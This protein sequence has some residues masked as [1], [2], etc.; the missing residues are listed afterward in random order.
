[1]SLIESIDAALAAATSQDAR[2]FRLELQ[3]D[4]IETLRAAGA[5]KEAPERWATAVG[6]YKTVPVY[7][8]TRDSELM[9]QPSA[10]STGLHIAIKT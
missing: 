1:M 9:A 5:L 10:S 4:E 3:S 8:A 2:P 6:G 7:S